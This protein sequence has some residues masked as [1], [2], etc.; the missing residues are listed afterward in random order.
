MEIY[1]RPILTKLT[2]FS[3]LFSL[4]PSSL[5]QCKKG[6]MGGPLFV[7]AK[8]EHECPNSAESECGGRG[9]C[10]QA[11][12]G[13]T[14]KAMCECDDG[15]FGAGCQKT[16]PGTNDLKSATNMAGQGVCGGHGVC[17]NVDPA[18]TG[19]GVGKKCLCNE[20]GG[21]YPDKL[22]GGTC[23]LS[24][25]GAVPSG[26]T[27]ATTSTALTAYKQ[28]CNGRGESWTA[29][30]TAHSKG[31]FQEVPV[32]SRGCKVTGAEP[33]SCG[34][35]LAKAGSNNAEARENSGTGPTS[36]TGA[37][38]ASQSTIVDPKTKVGSTSYWRRDSGARR[39]NLF[40]AQQHCT[41][42]H[43]DRTGLLAFTATNGY[44]PATRLAHSSAAEKLRKNDRA[45][46]RPQCIDRG[47]IVAAT[48]W[49]TKYHPGPTKPTDYFDQIRQCG[50]YGAHHYH[51]QHCWYESYFAGW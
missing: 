29:L 31:M 26:P 32:S 1:C 7:G 17:G 33:G 46:G 16:C 4:S 39:G 6:S 40:S 34:C 44:Q 48:T 12:V 10:K 3:L 51:V 38:Q 42:Y 19:H 45:E 13:K 8:C 28:V 41:C 18:L 24:C 23:A 21:W 22:S 49:Q 20:I 11:S 5:S 47:S 36:C 14:F 25:P 9:K 2:L 27:K 15:Y 50:S 35:D 30:N 43:G 37:D